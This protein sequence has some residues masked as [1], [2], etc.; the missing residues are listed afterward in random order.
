MGIAA[1]PAING[2]GPAAPPPAEAPGGTTLGTKN[3]AGAGGRKPRALVRT[4]A[5]SGCCFS[6]PP[7]RQALG[8]ESRGGR[9]CHRHTSARTIVPWWSAVVVEEEEEG[10]PG[11]RRVDACAHDW[12]G[13]SKRATDHRWR[14]R[15]AAGVW[16]IISATASRSSV[17]W[18][19]A[20]RRHRPPAVTTRSSGFR[21][22]SPV[23]P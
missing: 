19:A 11:R 14:R 6:A 21:E 13:A 10:E 5:L 23:D 8:I 1:W 15:F 7:G 2:H 18:A 20:H 16:R 22:R 12:R 4:D 9:I 3:S 17:T